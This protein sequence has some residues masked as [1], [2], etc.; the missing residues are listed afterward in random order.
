MISTARSS[1]DAVAPLDAPQVRNIAL[2]RPECRLDLAIVNLHTKF[3]ISGFTHYEDMKGNAK[4][5]NWGRLGSWGHP[6]LLIMSPFDRAGTT[7]Y[8][9]L[10]ETVH[11]SCTVFK[12]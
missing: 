1:A 7:S 4:C 11:L 3:E 5:R 9:T 10:T 2:E 6:R 8:L 12:L